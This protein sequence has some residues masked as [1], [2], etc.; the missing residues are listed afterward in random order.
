MQKC[1]FV[2]LFVGLSLSAGAQAQT[3][4]LTPGQWTVRHSVQVPAQGFTH[5]ETSQFCLAPENASITFDQ[6]L[7]E[8]NFAECSARNV[9]VTQST[10]RADIS[11][12]Y[13][14]YGNVTAQGVMTASYGEN[15]YRIE[16]QMQGVGAGT[17][18]VSYV[19]IGT[20]AGS[21]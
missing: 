7:K 18:N 5:N 1:F 12:S 9:V 8:L 3:I 4:D 6:I 17:I 11:C 16:A 20:L 2:A 15:A 10:G 19:G 21:C 13:P 14:D